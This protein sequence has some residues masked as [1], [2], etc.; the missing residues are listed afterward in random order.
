MRALPALPFPLTLPVIGASAFA[1]GVVLSLNLATAAFIIPLGIALIL[2]FAAFLAIRI[3]AIR[4]IALIISLTLCGWLYT[5]AHFYNEFQ[6]P[7]KNISAPIEYFSA[8]ITK[9][10]GLNRNKHSHLAMVTRVH[11]G[12]NW[13]EAYGTVRV[14]SYTENAFAPGTMLMVRAPIRMYRT[15]FA[16]EEPRILSIMEK[17]RINGVATIM[18]RSG[19]H[20]IRAAHPFSTWFQDTAFSMRTYIKKALG[21]HLSGNAYAINECFIL[22]D[23]SPIAQSLVTD[24]SKA[25]TMHILSVSG[26]HFGMI[27]LIVMTITALLPLN[28]FVRLALAVVLTVAVYTPLTLAVPPV[29]RSAVMAL[30]LVPV[31]LF[32]RTRNLTN[33]LFLTIFILLLISPNDIMDISFQLS[34]L[35][36]FA[37]ASLVGPVDTL[38]TRLP[39]MKHKTVRYAVSALGASFFASLAT[40]P[41]TIHY[42]GTANF[43]SIISNFT[44]VPLSFIMLSLSFLIIV[45]SPLPFISDWYAASLTLVTDIF[46][47]LNSFFAKMNALRIENLSLPFP[48]AAAISA[49]FIIGA[50]AAAVVL[51]RKIHGSVGMAGE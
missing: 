36:T 17:K 10:E 16:E 35:A 24:F 47:R 12:T 28:H 29:M 7:L 22:G 48:A 34:F 11:T 44:A 27:I 18:N 5:T 21:T 51:S 41:F 13:H 19:Y 49:A 20:V 15:M 3:Q 4:F 2:V 25:G 43:T 14:Y 32:D 26:L 38:L 42:F 30:L 46:L 40:L 8:K 31:A 45:F 9:Y 50:L 1:A 6:R 37:L 33:I 23:K 39:F